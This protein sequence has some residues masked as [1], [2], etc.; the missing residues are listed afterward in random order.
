MSTHLLRARGKWQSGP[1]GWVR[2]LVPEA[3][4]SAVWLWHVAGSRQRHTFLLRLTFARDALLSVARGQCPGKCVLHTFR[5]DG[6]VASPPTNSLAGQR[7]HL[8]FTL[9]FTRR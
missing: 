8:H 6:F 2:A 4:V 3:T 5:T 9:A 7:Q 1:Y